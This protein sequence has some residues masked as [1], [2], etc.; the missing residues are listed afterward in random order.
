M[1]NVGSFTK[2]VFGAITFG[3]YHFFVSVREHEQDRII[4]RIEHE[5]RMLELDDEIKRL[6]KKNFERESKN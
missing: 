2:G 3:G 6:T 4:R 1:N 5:K